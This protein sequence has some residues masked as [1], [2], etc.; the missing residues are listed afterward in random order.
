MGMNMGQSDRGRRVTK[1]RG[2]FI[3]RSGAMAINRMLDELREVYGYNLKLAIEL[4]GTP[5][6]VHAGP[7]R[8]YQRLI[9]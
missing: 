7:S 8:R 1:L 9:R 5:W 6:P 3:R 2:R 4:L